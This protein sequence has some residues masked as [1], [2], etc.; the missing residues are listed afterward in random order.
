MQQRFLTF[1]LV[2]FCSLQA[3]AQIGG[4]RS[5]EFLNVP[6]DAR[7]AAL[8]GVSVAQPSEDVNAFFNNP[9]LLDSTVDN[10]ATLSYL[11]YLGGVKFSNL[12]YAKTFERYG[13]W[14]LG[15]KYLNYGKIT[16][17]DESGF[18]LGDF[19]AN[20]LAIVIGHSINS[21]NFSIGGNL[22]LVLSNIASNK[23]NA[24][25]LDIGGAF[26]H[27]EKDLVIG[28]AIKNIGFLIKDYSE[29]ANT[30]LPFDIQLGVS[31]KP[32]HM[33]IRLSVTAYNL[34]KGDIAFFDVNSNIG[35][36]NADTE[37]GV[38]DKIFRHFVFAV[39]FEP[40]KSFNFRIGYNHLMRR[41]LRLEEI[42]GGSGF[43]TGFMFRIKWFEI[44]YSKAFFH[45]A[46]STNHLTLTSNF[47]TLIKKR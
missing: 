34:Y 7:T 13:T 44:A 38:A 22:K 30:T 5:F 42:S 31:M 20:E 3:T 24:V 17:Y 33:P 4:Q 43:S 28:L 1:M 26:K 14:V 8:G 36:D 2:L 47:N 15:L 21:G 12:A 35:R 27:P 40:S 10:Q 41:E 19:N 32:E 18:E 39:A 9:A 11:A 45:V 46:G 25:L 23:A 6:V 29:T 37:P 16:A